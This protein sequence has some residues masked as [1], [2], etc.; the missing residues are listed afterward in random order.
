MQ[1]DTHTL[2]HKAHN[3]QPSRVE[4]LAHCFREH[5]NVWFDGTH[6]SFAGKYAWRSRVS[7]CRRAP[8]FM[9]IRNRQRS[10]RTPEGGSFVVSEY[11]FEPEPEEQT[12]TGAA[13][14]ADNTGCRV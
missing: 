6:L 9:T 14:G 5:P 2:R 7:D 10:V 4:R 1:M 8:F 12:G 3:R 13:A 11:R